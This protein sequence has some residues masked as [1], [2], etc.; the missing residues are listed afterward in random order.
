MDSRVDIEGPPFEYIA[1]TRRLERQH[2]VGLQSISEDCI[3][4]IYPAVEL[5]QVPSLVLFLNS[6]EARGKRPEDPPDENCKERLLLGWMPTKLPVELL[7]Y[8]ISVDN[9]HRVTYDSICIISTLSGTG[10]GRNFFWKVLLPWAQEGRNRIADF[11]KKTK[12]KG[13]ERK[14]IYLETKSDTTIEEFAANHAIKIANEQKNMITVLMSGDGGIM[15]MVNGLFKAEL[16][17]KYQPPIISILPFGTGNALT[18]S[19][20]I[21][22]DMTRGLR[23]LYTGEPR[24]LPTFKVNFYPRANLIVDHGRRKKPISCTDTIWGA[25]VCS[26]GLHA[27]LV[28]D[29]DTEEYRKHGIARFGM[30]AKELLHP[31]DGSEPHRYNGRLSKIKKIEGG[32]ED[33]IPIPRTEH[34]YVLVTLVSNFEK[35]FKISPAS[36]PLDGKLWLLHFGHMTGDEVMG[37]VGGAYN[38]GKHVDNPAVTYEEVGGFIIEM[39]EDDARWRR[40]CIDGKIIEVEK[41]GRVEIRKE[42]REIVKLLV[43]RK[44]D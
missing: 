27:S 29:S 39:D 24:S 18:H 21:T 14:F 38:G 31:S 25:V 1:S 12:T 19:V 8:G 35:N 26:W 15:E 13:P 32:F 4:S 42:S 28:A 2:D 11:Q 17:D 43:P 10:E 44:E 23:T 20:G 30:A 9:L 34:S 36:K 40:I 6:P 3:V 41:D 37:I 33:I 5:D 16:K 22:G 7:K